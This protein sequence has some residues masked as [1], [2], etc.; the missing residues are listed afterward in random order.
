MSTIS[1]ALDTYL[2]LRRGL[3]TALVGP[4]A[5]L[6]R[7]VEFLDGEGASVVT[8][9]LALRWA[10]ASTATPATKASRLDDVRRFAAWLSAADPR[11]EVP[12]R[13]LLP[14]RYRRRAPYIYS[15]EEIE[16]IVRQAGQL[17]SPSGGA[18]CADL[19]HAFWTARRDRPPPERSPCPRSRR[20]R[21][22]RGRPVDSTH[23]VRQVPV[24]TPPRLC[25]QGV[26]ALCAPAGS[27]HPT[28]RRSSIPSRRGW[29]SRHAVQRPVQLRGRLAR[30]RPAPTRAR[31]PPRARTT[32]P[33]PPAP[34]RRKDARPLV[35]GGP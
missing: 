18:S 3:G 21:S 6:R 7:F 32:A 34:T 12:P 1:D 8:T 31:A 35:P 2:V 20:R 13:G 16:R 28:S 22:Q 4:G 29:H 26:E 24:R 15:D 27:S 25:T 5:H 30:G 14:D 23:Q 33:R 9:A 19:R 17:R 10:T 11:T